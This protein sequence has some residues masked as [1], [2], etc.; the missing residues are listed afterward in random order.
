V[1]TSHVHG[2]LLDL[3]AVELLDLAHHADI[4]SGDEVDGNTLA[5]ETSTTTD[6]VDVVL[7]VG[8]QVVVDDEG[9]LL[10]I[11]TTGKEVSGDEDTGRSGTELLHDDITL[12]LVH[13]AVH[14]RDGEVTGSELVGEPVD[15]PTGVAED[16]GLGDGDGLVQVG[17]GVELPVLLL[18]SNVELLDTFEGKL[19]LLDEDTDGV[20]H[21]LGGDLEDVLGHGGGQED[22]LGGLREQLEDVVDLLGETARQHLVGL[23]EDE[24]LHVVGLQDA[25]LDHVL[26]TAGSTDND[27][28]TILEGLH[29]V[30]DAGTTNAGVAL[31]VHEVTDGDDD[32]LDLLSELTGGGEDKCLAGLD[33]LVD[34]LEGRDGEG[35]RLSGTGLGL[36]DNIVAWCLCQSP[37]L[38][39][40]WWGWW[41]NSPLMT[42]MMARCW[43]ADGRSKP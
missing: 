18:D 21:E 12:G 35:G 14:G 4:V 24:H 15:L 33:A 43:M 9:D 11:D 25:T 17:Q 29:V 34:L 5:S 32:L 41:A 20:A 26:D 23:V 1:L 38:L 22:D 2:H 10:D 3:C 31:D 37:V 30:A 6:A 8:G 13:V 16:D 40:C 28:G 42:G 27:L 19:V 7:A 36:G 39:W